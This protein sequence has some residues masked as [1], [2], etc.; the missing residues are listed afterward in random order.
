MGCYAI[1]LLVPPD[2]AHWAEAGLKTLQIAS[3]PLVTKGTLEVVDW[4]IARYRVTARRQFV[5]R[6]LGL[7]DDISGAG[8]SKRS[9]HVI[10]VFVS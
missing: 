4:G 6:V 5:N 7:Y 9:H 10:A 8:G 3:A 1:W 2:R